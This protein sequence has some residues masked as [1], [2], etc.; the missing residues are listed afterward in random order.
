M[1]K[2]NLGRMDE[3]RTGGPG[4]AECAA[5]KEP[6]LHGSKSGDQKASFSNIQNQ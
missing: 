4:Q 6:I 2:E 5:L 1:V 3:E